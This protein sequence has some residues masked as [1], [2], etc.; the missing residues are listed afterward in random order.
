MPRFQAG[1]DQSSLV[2]RIEAVFVARTDGC[3]P[4]GQKDHVILGHALCPQVVVADAIVGFSN[5]NA[6]CA[7]LAL[8]KQ[9]QE[10]VA[11]VFQT[12]NTRAL[13]PPVDV[14]VLH[15]KIR[16]F[17]AG[18]RFFGRRAQQGGI[19]ERKTM[20]NREHVAGAPTDPACGH[21]PV[22]GLPSAA[23][24]Q[25]TNLK[26]MCRLDEL[27]LELPFAGARSWFVVCDEQAFLFGCKPPMR[28][29]RSTD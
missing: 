6:R 13:T 20:I 23:P 12:G 9:P 17:S 26:L 25:R 2:Y 27:Y 14:K 18:E 4:Q 10:P 1:I 8:T 7:E 24:G 22:A 3:H 16:R 29:A 28:F 15:A 11:E 21:C 5:T 19:A